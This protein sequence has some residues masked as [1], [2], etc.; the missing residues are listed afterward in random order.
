MNDI[1][2]KFNLFLA[3]ERYPLVLNLIYILHKKHFLIV[4][5]HIKFFLRNTNNN[6]I[7]FQNGEL[8]GTLFTISFT[9]SI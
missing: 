4:I 5:L 2:L 8:V 9:S 6:P 3:M 1:Y 7:R